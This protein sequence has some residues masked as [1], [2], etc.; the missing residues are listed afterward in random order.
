MFHKAVYMN[1]WAAINSVKIF[2]VIISLIN[3]LMS[4]SSW[5]INGF[6]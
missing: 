5:L 1:P 4:L 3:S 2:I 6:E